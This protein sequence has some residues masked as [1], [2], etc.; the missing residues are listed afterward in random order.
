MWSEWQ[1]VIDQVTWNKVC[2]EHSN[3]CSFLEKQYYYQVSTNK[4]AW[5]CL[6]FNDHCLY[7]RYCIS[8][9]ETP[10]FQTVSEYSDD[11]FPYCSSCCRESNSE[12]GRYLNI[13]FGSSFSKDNNLLFIYSTCRFAYKYKKIHNYEH[14]QRHESIKQNS[15]DKKFK[16]SESLSH[17]TLTNMKNN[18]V[19]TISEELQCLSDVTSSVSRLFQD[20]S[21]KNRVV[22]KPSTFED[23]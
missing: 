18:D 19:L 3:C 10:Q 11:L 16:Q 5:V 20:P 9:G 13:L 17:T 4:V 23:M 1:L 8:H 2:Y 12:V 6:S 15:S 7:I 14:K 22:P 21:P